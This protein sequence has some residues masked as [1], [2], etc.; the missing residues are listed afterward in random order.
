MKIRKFFENINTPQKN[1]FCVAYEDTTGLEKLKTFCVRMKYCRNNV[2]QILM[3]KDNTYIIYYN[4]VPTEIE[5]SNEFS[6]TAIIQNI[7]YYSKSKEECEIFLNS[8][9]YNI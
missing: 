5:L 1:D 7:H 9:K 3:I 2:G 6:I 8:E 4:N